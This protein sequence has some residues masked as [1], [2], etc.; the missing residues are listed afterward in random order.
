MMPIDP[1]RADAT[2][3]ELVQWLRSFTEEYNQLI[4]RVNAEEAKEVNK[5]GS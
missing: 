3:E 2:H 5:R 4:D 1:P